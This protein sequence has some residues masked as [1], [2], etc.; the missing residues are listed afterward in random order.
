MTVGGR[1]SCVVPSVQKKTGPVAGDIK[2]EAPD[3]DKTAVKAPNEKK[4]ARKIK[5]EDEDEDEDLINGVAD[6]E[7]VQNHSKGSKRAARYANRISPKRDR[8]GAQPKRTSSPLSKHKS[9]KHGSKEPNIASKRAKVED[10]TVPSDRR[11]SARLS[12][13]GT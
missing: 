7:G 5:D 4:R 2:K 9:S 8:K 10:R 12:S 3:S 11:R 13:Q 1:T 6:K